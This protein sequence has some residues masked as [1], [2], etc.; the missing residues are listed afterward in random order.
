MNVKKYEKGGRIM[1]RVISLILALMLVLSVSLSTVSAGTTSTTPKF[2]VTS[3][4]G[5]IGETVDV[6]IS[7]ENNPGI[8]ALQ[9]NVGY[10]SDDLELIS[11][12]D[13]G[14]FN[15][16]LSH[17]KLTKNPLIV[18]WYSSSSSDEAEDGCFATLKFKIL[19]NASDSEVVITYS[20]DNIFDSSFNNIKFDV[21][22]GT[23]KVN[24]DPCH[25]GHTAVV[26]DAVPPTCT[27]TGLTEGSHCSVCN[28]ILV[29]QKTVDVVD[30]NY[31]NGACT[32]CG[33]TLSTPV[34]V[35]TG[36][37]GE[38]GETVDVKISLENNPGITALQ[39]KVGYSS[40]DLK[41]LSIEDN[42]LFSN[43][44]TNSELSKNPFIISWYSTTSNDE[45]NNGC[46]ATLKFEILDGASNSEVSITYDEENVFDSSFDNVKFEVVSGNVDVTSQCQNGHTIVIDKAVDPTCTKTGLT[47]GS[48]CSVCNTVLI[49]Q[50]VVPAKGHTEVI[51]KGYAPTDTKPGLTDG[52]HCSVCNEIIVKQE[53]IPM[54]GMIGDVNLDGY[55]NIMDVTDVQRYIAQ[56]ITFTDK[57]M[58]YADANRDGYI[59][60]MDA[61]QI[62][63]YIAKLITEF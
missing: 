33:T 40:K 28:T 56:Y 41:L 9:M 55:I 51:D 20:E 25:N 22:N 53:V 12:E 26:D 32:Y 4:Q 42:G 39:I 50:K 2:I 48:H 34:F 18:S 15:D 49:E 13:E 47:E 14:L 21:V 6:E 43:A 36:A 8:T 44:I 23:V 38:V 52:S 45:A 27:M 19:D 46:F 24:S 7:L 59:N 1:K 62:Q 10:S 37:Q 54:L 63:R 11:I 58:D 31:V 60:I 29:E 35:V 16:S 57:Q 30:H 3:V 61:T 5:E 17:S